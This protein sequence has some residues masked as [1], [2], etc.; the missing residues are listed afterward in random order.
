MKYTEDIIIILD[1]ILDDYY[2]L[3]ECFQDY[4]QYKESEES[5]FISFSGALQEAYD[6]KLFNF[7]EGEN[8]NG[9]EILIAE[10][11]LTDTNIQ[12]LLDWNNGTET[13][14]RIAVSELGAAF[15]DHNR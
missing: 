12:E 13:E 5:L 14:I 2:F 3:W 8:F 1:S 11:S 15:L 4:Q 6:H 10:F 9:D 7:F